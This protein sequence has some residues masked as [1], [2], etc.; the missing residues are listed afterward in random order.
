MGIFEMEK[1]DVIPIGLKKKYL[2]KSKDQNKPQVR[3]IPELRE[4]IHFSRINFMDDN[5]DISDNLDVVFCRN[6]L[7]YFDKPTQ[8]K[9]LKKIIYKM[10]S[11][12][13]LFLGHSETIM[14]MELSVK[15]VASTIYRK[16]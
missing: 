3:F 9:V 14:G 15:R 8:E 1:A 10:S 16:N 4:Q 2:L 12:G 5:Y 13:H 11:G 7:I 6:V